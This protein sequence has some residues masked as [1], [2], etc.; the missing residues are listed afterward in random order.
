MREDWRTG[1]G[2]KVSKGR[3]REREK[4]IGMYVR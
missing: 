4:V 3:E 2:G 1:R